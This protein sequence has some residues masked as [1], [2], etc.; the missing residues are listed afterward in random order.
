MSTRLDGILDKIAEL[1]LEDQEMVD[2]IIHTT[3]SGGMDGYT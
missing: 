1:S 3:E 2:E